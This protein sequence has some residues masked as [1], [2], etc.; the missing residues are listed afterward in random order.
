MPDYSPEFAMSYPAY[1]P[2]DGERAP[3]TQSEIDGNVMPLPV[4]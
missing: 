4:T 3:E 1:V 2:D